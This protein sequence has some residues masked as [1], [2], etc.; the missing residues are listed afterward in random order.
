MHA[1]VRF[2]YGIPTV[3]FRENSV[4]ASVS[5][6]Q[7]LIFKFLQLLKDNADIPNNRSVTLYSALLFVVYW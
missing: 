4:L 2:G 1:E 6:D 5:F 7:N 3:I